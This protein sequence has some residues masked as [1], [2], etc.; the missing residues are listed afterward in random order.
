MVDKAV[1]GRQSY[2]IE[3]I[4]IFDAVFDFSFNIKVI[5]MI[6]WLNSEYFKYSGPIALQTKELYVKPKC[7]YDRDM[8]AN[9]FSISFSYICIIYV[10][11]KRI[12]Y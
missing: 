7:T 11:T 8:F 9:I 2:N 6:F 5:A 10:N 1:S 4:I 12:L 3:L